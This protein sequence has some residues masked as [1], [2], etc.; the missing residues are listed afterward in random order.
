MTKIIIEAQRLKRKHRHGIEIFSLELLKSM[1]G[2]TK[3]GM[4][5]VWMRQGPNE[6][7]FADL[8]RL[9][10][11]TFGHPSYPL[12]EQVSLPYFL[13]RQQ[14]DTLLHCTG[15]T[16]PL[17]GNLP[18]V[19]TLHDVIFMDRVAGQRQ[20]TWYQQWGNRYRKWVAPTAAQAA[21]K[22]VT[23]SETEKKNILNRLPLKEHQVQV[24]YNGCH[25][26]FRPIREQASLLATLQKYELSPGFILHLA[27]T[28]PKKNTE[29]VLRAFEHIHHHNPLLDLVLVN[30]SPKQLEKQVRN[31]G[32][33]PSI[34]E[35]IRCL[36]YVDNDDLPGLYNLADVFLFPSLQES[37]GLPLIEAMACGTPVVT[38]RTS[39][40]PEIAGNAAHYVHAKDPNAMAEGVLHV[41]ADDDYAEELVHRGFGRR[42]FFTWDRAAQAYLELYEE[43]LF[44]VNQRKSH[45]FIRSLSTPATRPG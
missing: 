1:Q 3:P 30:C 36:P 27:N 16:A 24:I 22:V 10:L 44:S 23:V 28:D 9:D 8:N 12:F 17:W 19:V 6:A 15:N 20:R 7:G 43:C 38:C 34:L 40:L 18:F 11:R 45:S 33:T 41:L 21:Q 32:L 31:L 5:E 42:E 2:W 13:H 14:P 29:T 25:E 39:C 37:F 4:V 26:K 35:G